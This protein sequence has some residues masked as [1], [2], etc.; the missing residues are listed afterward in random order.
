MV[1]HHSLTNDIT[2]NLV[3]PTILML[4]GI[5]FIEVARKGQQWCLGSRE[6][7]ASVKLSCRAGDNQEWRRPAKWSLNMLGKLGQR[8]NAAGIASTARVVL[9]EPHLA[10]PH[11]SVSDITAI[12]WYAL[13]AIGFQGVVLDKDN[14][15]TAPYANSIWP[16]LA[17][18]LDECKNVFEGKIALLSNSAGLYQYDPDGAEAAL[19]EKALDISVIRHGSKKPSGSPLE[20]ERHFGCD[21]SLLVMVGDRYF[22]DVV[23]G[24][25]NG[26]LTIITKPLTFEG[27]P[28]IVKQVRNL[29]EVFVKRWGEKGIAPVKHRLISGNPKII[30]YP[31]GKQC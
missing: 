28:F 27:E 10:L 24:N 13:R 14:T 1:A 20:L 21:A 17:T 18:S 19:L 11:F 23:Y 9:R 22:T 4:S 26:L 6:V 7:A 15:I 30:K 8:F 31:S 29:E 2:P 5:K 25:R 3:Y 12:D 16:S